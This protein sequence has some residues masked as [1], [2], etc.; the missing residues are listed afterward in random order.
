MVC[1]PGESHVMLA[2]GRPQSRL[3]RRQHLLRW[4]A[5]YLRS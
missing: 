3:V 1:F 2:N 4:F 5:T